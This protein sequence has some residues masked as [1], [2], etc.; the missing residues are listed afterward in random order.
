MP[1]GLGSRPK[2]YVSNPSIIA[3][4]DT[5]LAF[6]FKSRVY[7]IVVVKEHL[8]DTP[9]S[10][11]QQSLRDLAARDGKPGVTGRLQL[12]DIRGNEQGLVTTPYDGSGSGIIWLERGVEYIIRGP[13]LDRHDVVA[14]ANAL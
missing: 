4:R 12:F 7:G 11:Y 9:P 5:V 2:I 1:K 8:P 6:V 3:R 14:I 13:E 10:K